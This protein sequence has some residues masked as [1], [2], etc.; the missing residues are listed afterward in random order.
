MGPQYRYVES[1]RAEANGTASPSPIV[2]VKLKRKNSHP[3]IQKRAKYRKLCTE[4]QKKR[5]FSAQPA[6]E[7]SYT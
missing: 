4:R 5:V 6:E 7:K 1:V 3:E 2:C